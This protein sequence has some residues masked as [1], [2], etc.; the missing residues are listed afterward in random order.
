M[1][2]LVAL[3]GTA[4]LQPN[5]RWESL[6]PQRYLDAQVFTWPHRLEITK[7][8]ARLVVNIVGRSTTVLMPDDG[9]KVYI[10]PVQQF[11]LVGDF[12]TSFDYLFHTVEE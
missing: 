8:S 12:G 7:V 3:P 11:R 5:G 2:S 1:L 9:Q 6:L 4:S 10:M